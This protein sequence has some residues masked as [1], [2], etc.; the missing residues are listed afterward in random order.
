MSRRP[1]RSASGFSRTFTAACRKLRRRLAQASLR[2][3]YRRWHEQG[4][5]HSLRTPRRR[6]DRPRRNRR[7]ENDRPR[8]GR[9]AHERRGGRGS[10]ETTRRLRREAPEGAQ[11]KAAGSS[12]GSEAKAGPCPRGG[13]GCASGAARSS[14]TGPRPSSRS[15]TPTTTV[16]TAN[17]TAEMEEAAMTSHHGRLY[18]LALGLVVF[19]LAW[20]VIASHPWV[21]A[22]AD[23]RLH[24]LAIRQ[25][26]LQRE[27][28][29]VRK[30]GCGALGEVPHR[31]EGPPGADRTR[32]RGCGG[33]GRLGCRG[34]AGGARSRS[35]PRAGRE[36]AGCPRGHEDVVK[37]DPTFWLL[38]RAS[39]LTAY[40][41]L[42][43]FRS[44][45][46]RAEVEAARARAQ[47][48]AD[49][50]RAPVSRAARPG[51]ARAARRDVAARSDAAH[52]ARRSRRAW[53]RLPIAPPRWRSAWSPPS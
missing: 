22:S 38:A 14:T 10:H 43:A 49:D 41:L 45:R 27:A 3:A 9:A 15:S 12:P 18:T 53:A 37:T 36:P 40:G 23:P 26:Q 30:V 48:R 33:C 52:A 20:A 4:A 39:G 32:Q 25:A 50:G 51:D 5:C 8:P 28:K 11:G 21:T 17:P 35:G 29:L 7:D 6:R 42:T 44:R 47:A 16:T 34:S 31:V 24:T 1:G 13:T 2:A 19:F 46:P